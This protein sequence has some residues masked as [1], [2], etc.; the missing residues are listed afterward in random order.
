M[1]FREARGWS[2]ESTIGAI[3]HLGDST[4]VRVE[5]GAWRVGTISSFALLGLFVV[6]A[7]LSLIAVVR[8]IVTRRLGTS[9][10]AAVGILLLGSPLISPQFFAWLLPGAAIAWI[11]RERAPAI[12][13]L[14]T[15][16]LSVGIL[17]NYADLVRG[18]RYVELLVIGRN[19][20][21]LAA[22]ISAAHSLVTPGTHQPTRAT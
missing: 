4:G 6:T 16:V 20:M 9:W 3:V 17:A 2:I 7:P 12:G 21:C 19:L 22:V 13:V 14:V 18:V 11:D 1:T 5:S 10:I 15:L 8:G